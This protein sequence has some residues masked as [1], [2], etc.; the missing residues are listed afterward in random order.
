MEVKR[1]V[2]KAKKNAMQMKLTRE[3]YS[4]WLD[5]RRNPPSS[6]ITQST[7]WHRDETI[8]Q[9]SAKEMW[10]HNA[11]IIILGRMR[12]LVNK[13]C[14]LY[15]VIPQT[16]TDLIFALNGMKINKVWNYDKEDDEAECSHSS[17]YWTYV[18]FERGVHEAVHP[19]RDVEFHS[20]H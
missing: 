14:R 18:L 13:R 6:R 17:F 16:A 19:E 1:C 10:I 5:R 8:F 20:D 7:C 9:M 11:D 15:L 3:M 4:S 2:E 12:S